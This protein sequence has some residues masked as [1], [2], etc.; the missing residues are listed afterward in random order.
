MAADFCAMVCGSASGAG[1]DPCSLDCKWREKEENSGFGDKTEGKSGGGNSRKAVRSRNTRGD[2]SFAA[3]DRF[4]GKEDSRAIEKCSCGRKGQ[5]GCMPETGEEKQQY[6][7]PGFAG[8][9]YLCSAG[10]I[11]ICN[12]SMADS[13]ESGEGPARGGI[14]R[15]VFLHQSSGGETAGDSQNGERAVC[16]GQYFCIFVCAGSGLFSTA[17]TSLCAGGTE[18]VEGLV[19]WQPGNCCYVVFGDPAVSRPGIYSGVLLGNDG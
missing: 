5:R 2:F 18:S 13:A 12:H 11:D 14:F 7:N 3:K 17:G 15:D 1:C 6:G 10:G 8:R 16:V 4:P 9:N 19:G